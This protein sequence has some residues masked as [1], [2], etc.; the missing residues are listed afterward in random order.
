MGY[1][2]LPHARTSLTLD[3]GDVVSI[4]ERLGSEELRDA[5]G[6]LNALGSSTNVRDQTSF[7]RSI[8]D[9]L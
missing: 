6:G 9:S 1:L 7:V 3:D 4:V 2:T 8:G 5:T